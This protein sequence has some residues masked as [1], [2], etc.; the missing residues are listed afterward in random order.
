MEAGEP[1]DVDSLVQKH[2]ERASELRRLLPAIQVL[3]GLEQSAVG[4]AD[5]KLGAASEK[6]LGELGDFPLL[7]QIG[8]GGMGVVYEADQISLSRRVALKVLPFAAA[9]DTKHLQRFRN[10]AQ[11]PLT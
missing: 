1:I 7:R 8:R 4:G 9:L 3:A 6:A 2:P 11:R 5:L 10:E